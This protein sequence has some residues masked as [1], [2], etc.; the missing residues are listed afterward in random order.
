[1]KYVFLNALILV[2]LLASS[3]SNNEKTYTLEDL[4]KG[5][6]GLNPRGTYF[7][8]EFGGLRTQ[9][10]L[11]EKE[12]MILGRWVELES[13]VSG[14]YYFYPNKLFAIGFNMHKFKEESAYLAHIFGVW[15]IRNDRLTVKIY[16]LLKYYSPTDSQPERYEYM[17]VSPYEVD[18][19]DIKDIDPIGYSKKPFMNFVF[20][21][22]I[23]RLITVPD[24]SRKGGY[25]V[26][27]LYSILVITDSGKP[28]KS[29]DL[30]ECFPEMAESNLTGLD[31]V[32]NPGI[33][34][35]YFGIPVFP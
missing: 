22:E 6:D 29:Y 19:I 18:I 26:R 16:S 2:F 11:N 14:N 24:G 8:D 20:P 12:S 31:I 32:T 15:D 34:Y 30:F 27:S 5:D 23:R 1:M 28:E 7:W 13:H 4:Q 3:C 35:K 21:K 10:S 33:I 17:A 9:Y 25:M